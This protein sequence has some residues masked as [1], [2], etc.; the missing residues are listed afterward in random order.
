MAIT[1][2]QVVETK[3]HIASLKNESHPKTAPYRAEV[4]KGLV[5]LNPEIVAEQ[6][7]N[8]HDRIAEAKKL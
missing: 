7:N 4:N 3:A 2:N 6:I 5:V 8:I 1:A